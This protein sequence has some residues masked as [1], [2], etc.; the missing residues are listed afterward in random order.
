MYERVVVG[1][2]GSDTAAEA[3]RQAAELAKLC[4]ARL[5]IVHVFQPVSAI[6]TMGADAGAAAVA[7][8]LPE[9]AERHASEVL[10]RA[11][12][13]GTRIGVDVEAHLHTGDPANALIE[14]AKKVDADLV[15]VGNKGMSGV[16]R[17]VLGSVPNKLSHHAPCSLLIVNTAS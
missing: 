8:G 11:A 6:A 7:A 14:T 12:Q 5:H 9:A 3:V 13:A 15:V 17:F 2:D 10:E 4:G 1:T 16:R